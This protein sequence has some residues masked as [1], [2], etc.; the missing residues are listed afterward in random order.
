D[1]VAG[2]DPAKV[3]GRD[4]DRLPAQVAGELARLQ[5]VYGTPSLSGRA[6]ATATIRCSSSIEIRRGR[7]PPKR[8]RSDSNPRSLKSWITLRTCDSSVIHIR[9]ICGALINVFEASRIDA[10]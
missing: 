7:P 9:A 4:N 2:K 3:R 6:P 1:P 5:R 8:G 10:R